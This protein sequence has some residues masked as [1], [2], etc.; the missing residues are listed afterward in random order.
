MRINV[1]DLRVGGFFVVVGLAF[2]LGAYFKI[3]IGSPARMGPGFFPLLLSIVLTF[4]GLLICLQTFRAPADPIRFVPWR[5]LLLLLAAPIAF[6]TTVRGL[7]FVPAVMLTSVLAAFASPQHRL[8]DVVFL[9]VGM[10]V[11][12]TFVFIM[13]AGLPLD[14][15]GPWL[16]R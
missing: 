6:G 5:G 2:G 8:E 11:F 9:A 12:C 3:P 14:L 16:R 1:K 10:A 4:L 7:G 15:I 13:A